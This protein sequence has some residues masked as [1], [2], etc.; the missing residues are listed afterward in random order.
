[1][2]GPLV[3]SRLQV[4]R[5]D[6]HPLPLTWKGC[7]QQPCPPHKL[8]HSCLPHSCGHPQAQ[9]KAGLGWAV[10]KQAFHSR[11]WGFSLVRGCPGLRWD[12]CLVSCLSAQGDEICIGLHNVYTVMGNISVVAAF[13]PCFHAAHTHEDRGQECSVPACLVCSASLMSFLHV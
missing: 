9:V 5:L 6:L 13:L 12:T 7:S 1:M 2:Q 10:P 4:L 3:L 8:P 11:V